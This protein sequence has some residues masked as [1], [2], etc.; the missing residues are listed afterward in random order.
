MLKSNECNVLLFAA[1]LGTRLRPYTNDYPKPCWPLFK[2]PM[3][4]YLLPYMKQLTIKN[5]VVNTFHLPAKV[6]GLYHKLNMNI[7]FSNETDFI[8]GSGGGYKQASLLFDLR[9]PTILANADEV[10]FTEDSAFITQALHQHQLNDHLATLIVMKH[11]K[12][13]TEFGAI[14]CEGTTVKHIGKLSADFTNPQGWLPYHF[15]GIQILNNRILNEIEDNTESNIFYDVLIYKLNCNKVKIHL[16]DADWFE[17]GNVNDYAS[18]KEKISQLKNQKV[19]V[20][21]HFKN[22]EHFPLSD[23]SDLA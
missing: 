2:I 19:S 9:Q 10:L 14:W 21:E 4:Y 18:S 8:K 1:G 16:I 12:A 20:I 5:F 13:G 17:M 15:I 7:Q 11:E 6:Q 22:L 23:L 3:G